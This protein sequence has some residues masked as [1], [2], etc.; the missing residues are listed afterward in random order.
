MHNRILLRTLASLGIAA[1]LPLAPARAGAAS[2][3]PDALDAIAAYAPRAMRE[4]GTPGLS[5]AITDRTRTLR[6]ITLGYANRETQS[7]VT[8]ETRFAI[9]S[10]TKS[11]TALALLELRDSGNLDLGAPVRRYLPW[12]AIKSLGGP[13]LVHELLSHTAGIPDDYAAEPGYVYD[14][15]A[16]RTAKTLFAPGTSWS[17][18]NDGY[19]TAGAVLA[20]LDGRPW[21]DALQARVLQPIGMMASSPVFTP[22]RMTDAAVG[23]QFRDN[24]R[25]ASLAPPLV[26]S[27]SFDFVDPAG[28][29][30]ST[31][32]DMARYIRFYLNGGKTA[33][34]RRLISPATFAAMTSADTFSNGKPAGSPSTVLEEAPA[35]YRQYGYGLATFE[36]G[37]DHL[38]GHTGGISGY[39]ACMQANLTRGYGVI[40]FAN[41]V[42]APLHPCAIVLY[43]M[44][45]LRAQ[46]LGEPLPAAPPAADPAHV[47][48]AAEYEGTYSE[49]GSPPLRVA[50]RGDRLYLEDAGREIALYSRGA[51]LFWA[52]APQFAVFLVAFGRDRQNKVVEMSYGSRWWANER[53]RGPQTF[54]HPASWNALVGRYENTFFGQPAITRAVI[55]KDKLTL[56]GVSPLRVLANGSFALGDSI[57]TFDASAGGRAQRLN[58]DDTHFY[59]VEL[60]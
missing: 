11:M 47:A 2:G 9:G 8:G 30:L 39:T 43:A 12:F 56:D 4:Q 16:L 42:E 24:D 3:M 40:A 31:P 34:G 57:V 26:P 22:D 54:A 18:S 7:P 28:S 19:A 60:P 36:D 23:Y 41:L 59:R 51:D 17:Y 38:I 37:G 14:V 1:L 32:E 49:A 13:I 29:V 48:R 55:V 5:M 10:I 25:P 50:A 53:Y 6:V 21:P 20:R 27:P 15:W 52:D 45:V 35:F 46:S 44:K 58:I 33:G